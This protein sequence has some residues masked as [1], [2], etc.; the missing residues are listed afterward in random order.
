VGDYSEENPPARI[1]DAVASGEIDVAIAW[2]PLAGYFSRR[3]RVPLFIE[4][5]SPQV[6]ASGLPFAYDISMGVRRNNKALRDE[7]DR[8]IIRNRAQIAAIL[9]EY[10]IP[11]V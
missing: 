5:V 9:A 1:I 10:G 11:V 4:P 2:G 6:D 8:S 7:L 3:S